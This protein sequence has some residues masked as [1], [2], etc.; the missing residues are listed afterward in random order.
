MIQINH[1]TTYC[2]KKSEYHS[3]TLLMNAYLLS[4]TRMQFVVNQFP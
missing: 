4:D 1:H 3:Y 2:M